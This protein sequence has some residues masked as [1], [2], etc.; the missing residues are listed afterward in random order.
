MRQASEEQGKD[1][2]SRRRLAPFAEY[3]AK[4]TLHA[5]QTGHRLIAD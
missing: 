3:S 1:N 2:T 5:E 4:L